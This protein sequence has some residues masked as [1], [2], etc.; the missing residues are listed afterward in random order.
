MQLEVDTSITDTQITAHLLFL[1]LP[2]MIL[3][4]SMELHDQLE[5]IQAIIT[6]ELLL[7]QM[8]I[9]SG[10]WQEMRRNM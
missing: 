7:S 10:I 2:Q 9:S 3:I 1:P 5:V 4:A 8:E 6:K